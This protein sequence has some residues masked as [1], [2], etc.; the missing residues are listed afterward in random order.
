MLHTLFAFVVFLLGQTSFA[1]EERF[2]K[3]PRELTNFP[4]DKRVIFKNKIQGHRIEGS[5][6]IV[7]CNQ[8]T[9]IVRVLNSQLKKDV[10]RRSFVALGFGGV[11]INAPKLTF[12]LRKK[13]YHDHEVAIGSGTTEISDVEMTNYE[14][15]YM[16]TWWNIQKIKWL[17]IGVEGGIGRVAL[18]FPQIT[19]GSNYQANAI[20]GFA[21]LSLRARWDFTSALSLRGSLGLSY[22]TLPSEVDL[23]SNRSED[24]PRNG[25]RDYLGILLAY[26]F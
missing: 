21:A 26:M 17:G 15:S 9:C 10:P 5:C 14:L 1:S 8:D 3:V 18:E 23:E 20:Y 19:P 7:K 2:L 13:L 24:V 12:G 6:E 4:N 22:N 11:L 16:S 25:A